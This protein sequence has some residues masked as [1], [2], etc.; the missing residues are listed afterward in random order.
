[1]KTATPIYCPCCDD[2]LSVTTVPLLLTGTVKHKPFM[3]DGLR[4]VE[5]AAC[6]FFLRLEIP[7]PQESAA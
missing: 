6:G 1:M 3:P 7:P 4:Y 5:C 2:F